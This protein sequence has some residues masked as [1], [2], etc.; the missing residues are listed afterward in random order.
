LTVCGKPHSA[1]TS[2]H[3]LMACLILFIAS[4]FVRPWL[5]HPGMDGHWLIQTPSS[6]RST[7]TENR[8]IAPLVANTLPPLC[9]SIGTP[10]ANHPSGHN[11]QII[12]AFIGSLSNQKPT[13]KPWAFDFLPKTSDDSAAVKPP[14]PPPAS[15]RHL[16]PSVPSPAHR[17]SAPAR[18]R[19]PH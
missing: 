8:I 16:F 11:D 9:N 19:L 17:S 7:V 18:S 12:L 1:R 13:A 15:I 6:S 5:T 4:A 10:A 3:N 14:P 2:K